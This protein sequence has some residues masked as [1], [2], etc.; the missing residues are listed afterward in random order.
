M[1]EERRG[2]AGAPALDAQGVRLSLE[3]FDCAALAATPW[4]NGGGTTCEIACWPPGAGLADFDWRASIARIG[5]SGPFS[6]FPG[7]A[8]TILLLDGAGV[9]LRSNDGAIDHR[10][11]T[12]LEPF[13]FDGAAALDCEL[14]GAA[15]S[16]FNVMVRRGR[17][18]ADLTVLRGAAALPATPHGVLL[19][20]RG[21]WH[22][23]SVSGKT[24]ASPSSS[25]KLAAGEGVCWGGA[26]HALRVEG[27]DADA[28]LIAVLLH[29]AA[30][31]DGR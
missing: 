17:F 16:D 29:P 7:V 18:V 23:R 6:I 1:F 28:A 14:L 27:G 3:R 25:L 2:I 8:R 20:W 9:R 12:P 11:D 26:S 19:A 31:S 30:G 13:A 21:D 4:K 15:S 5:A 24:L 10:L 22:V